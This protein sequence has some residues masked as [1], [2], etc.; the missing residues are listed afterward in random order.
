VR[1]DHVTLWSPSL[2][3][4]GEMIAYGHYGRPVLVFPP[5]RGGASDYENNGMVDALAPLVD[6]GRIK[7]YCVDSFDAGSWSAGHLPLEERARQHGRYEQWIIEQVT[8]WIHADCGGPQDTIVTGVSLGAHHAA[9]LALR[10]ADLFPVAICLSGVYD[11]ASS[12]WGERGDAFYFNN[13]AD[14]VANLSGDHLEW[15]RGRVF[16]ALVC[17]Q[18]QWEDT[19]GALNS[20]RQ[21]AGLLAGRGIKHEMDLWGYDVPHDWPSWR[22]QLAHHLPRFC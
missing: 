19:T 8:P 13:P 2:Q 4:A 7:L 12:G 1:R 3:A 11:L 20:T 18:G 9:N 10:R 17:G 14:Y 5:E 22:A 6:S 16:L 21:F 15:L